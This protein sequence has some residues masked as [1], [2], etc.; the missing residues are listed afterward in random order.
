MKKALAI[1]ALTAAAFLSTMGPAEATGDEYSC[2]AGTEFDYKVEPLSG[3]T[4]T[5]PTPPDGW[6]I[7]AVI[8]KV[9]G[10][11]GG[12]HITFSPVTPGQ[13]LD[14]S[15]Q[16]YDISHA[17]VCKG[18]EEETTTSTSTTTS[19]TTTLPEEETTTTSTT[20]PTTTS[21][22][23]TSSVPGDTTTTTVPTETTVTTTT[24]EPSSTSTT[25]QPD[26]SSTTTSLPSLPTTT[27]GVGQPPVP[28]NPA[29]PL[30]PTPTALPVT[31]TDGAKAFTPWAILALSLGG[32]ATLIARRNQDEETV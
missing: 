24:V 26:T 6:T 13:V 11:G 23:T 28:Q 20:Q 2:P 4:F 1:F 17:H 16:Q 22:S 8:L 25:L 5:V 27:V 10:P 18:R 3:K 14:V 32:I 21:T 15:N 9:G 31:G 30:D 12:S 7:T 29:A 19:T